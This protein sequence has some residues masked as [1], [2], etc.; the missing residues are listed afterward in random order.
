MKV[1]AI[2]DRFIQEKVMDAF[3]N[4]PKIFA[5]RFLAAHP[6]LLEGS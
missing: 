1:L 5:D 2:G 3:A 4:S 6:K